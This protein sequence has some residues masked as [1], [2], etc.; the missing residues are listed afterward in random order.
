MLPR[1]SAISYAY[2]SQKTALFPFLHRFLKSRVSQH[3][4]SLAWTP[5]SLP[6]GLIPRHCRLIYCDLVSLFSGLSIL[7]YAVTPFPQIL[8][9]LASGM[10]PVSPPF[11]LF[12]D[13]FF[14]TVFFRRTPRIHSPIRP[15]VLF[16]PSPIG[17][18]LPFLGTISTSPWPTAFKANPPPLYLPILLTG[19]MSPSVCF[20]DVFSY[21]D[22]SPCVVRIFTKFMVGPAHR[23]GD[24]LGW[25]VRGSIIFSI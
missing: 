13:L 23:R 14:V 25:P 21:S 5:N 3:V 2:Q 4:E 7:A 12:P 9:P 18:R 11:R 15:G 20:W 10:F 8:M 24:I 22:P 17:P 19:I 6:F 16:P 1:V